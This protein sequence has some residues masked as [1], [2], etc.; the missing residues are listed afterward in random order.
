MLIFTFA[1]TGLML[2]LLSLYEVQ[3]F[4]RKKLSNRW[5]WMISITAI[6]LCGFGI[7]LGRFLRWNS[8]D[9][10]SNPIALMRD[11]WD[12]LFH[13]EIMPMTMSIT[14]ILSIFLFL[15]YLTLIT[16]IDSPSSKER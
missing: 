12:S 8:W 5:S 14:L 9:I 16:L 15:G 1:W 11:I 13:P 7:Y 3:L 6:F 10:L 4:F 2:G